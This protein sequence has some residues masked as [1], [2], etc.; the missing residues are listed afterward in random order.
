MPWRG[1][2]RPFFQCVGQ[3]PF[4]Y[5]LRGENIFCFRDAGGA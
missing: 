3:L 4:D 1:S 2:S 5:L